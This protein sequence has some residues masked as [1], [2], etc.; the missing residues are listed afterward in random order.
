VRTRKRKNDPQNPKRSIPINDL[1]I[2]GPMK[3]E[4]DPNANRSLSVIVLIFMLLNGSWGSGQSTDATAVDAAGQKI[5][6]VIATAH[7]D[8]QWRWTIQKTI[9]EYIPNTLRGNFALLKKYPDYRFSFEGAFRYMLA[10]EYYPEDYDILRQYILDGRWNVCG[11]AVD[12]GDANI[13]SPESINRHIL[14]G[15]NYFR[16]EFGV[17]SRDIFLPDCF[18]FG[19][20]LPAVAAHCG[21]K[22]F[23]TQKLT[24]G[25]AYGVPFDIGVWEGVNGSSLVAELNPGAYISQIR[26]D[27]SQDSEWLKTINATGEKTSLYAGYKYF[28]V[29]DTGGAPDDS[30]IYWL[31]KSIKG[32]GP[33]KVISEAADQLCRDLSPEQIAKLP[34]YKGELL[35]STH[36][37]GCYTAQSAMKRW[38][39]HNELLADAAERAAVIAD[40]LGGAVYPREKLTTAWIRFLWHQFHDDLTGTSIPEA[41]G[42]SWNDEILS[43]NQFA[44]VL[45]DGVG[46]V[47]RGLDTQCEGVPIV[48]YNPLSIARRAVAQ[49]NVVFNNTIQSVQVFDEQNQEVPSQVL[50]KNG[51]ECQVL[52]LASVPPLGFKVYA[53]RASSQPC[54]MS[55]ELRAARDK[56]EN[57][58]YVV[59]VDANG[60]VSSIYDKS[61]RREL[62]TAPIQLQLLDDESIDWPAWEI[63]HREIVKPPRAFVSNPLKVEVAENGPVRV[64]I[65]IIRET[66]GST[67]TQFVRL[68]GGDDGNRVDFD[69]QIMWNTGGTLL[70]ACFPLTV[71]NPKATYDLGLG[72]IERP[73]NSEKLYE[74][75]AQQWADLTAV[76]GSYGIALLNDCKYGWDKP[77]DQTLRLTLIH[78]P[79]PGQNYVDQAG[80]DLGNHRMLF[81]VQGHKGPWNEGRVVWNAAGLN[82]PLLC[83]QTKPQKGQ[84][85]KVISF[86]NVNYADRVAIR[87]LKKSEEGDMM[88]VRLAELAGKPVENVQLS[89]HGAVESFRELNGAEEPLEKEAQDAALENGKLKFK[90]GPFQLRTFAV[91]L[92]KS[93]LLLTPPV[94]QPVD[95]GFDLDVACY[96]GNISDGNFDGRGHALAAELLPDV[97]TA[98]GITFKI[99]PRGIGQKNG[100]SCQGQKIKLPKGDFDC[101]YLL[102]AATEDTRDVFKV[103]GRK[104]D[105]AVQGYSGFI[106]QWDSRLQD[107][108]YPGQASIEGQ[109]VAASQITPSFIKKDNVAWVGTYR[110]D[111]INGVV[112]PYIFTYLYKYELELDS[113]ADQLTLP[114]NEKIRVFAVTM[115]KNPN[116]ATHVAQNLY[117]DSSMQS[118]VTVEPQGSVRYFRDSLQVALKSTYLDDQ[119][120]YSLDGSEPDQ[121]MLLY[122]EPFVIKE[123]TVVKAR[124]FNPVHGP[125]FI[126]VMPLNKVTNE[127]KPEN[128]ANTKSGLF[129]K[130][131]EG[132]WSQL[133]DF[134][135]LRIVKS[136]SIPAFRIPD[137]IRR[138]NF[139][140]L[141][142]GF[143]QIEKE[144]VYV[145][146][147]SSDDGSRLWIGTTRVVDNDGLHGPVE[148]AGAIYLEPGLHSIAVSFF[149]AGGG[150]DLT[151]NFEGPGISRQ[152]IPPEILFYTE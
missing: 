58:R 113:K 72:V 12:A 40:W 23:S 13:P 91:Q 126:S 100:S 109:S 95:L 86:A 70:K 51:K 16:K 94:C 115:A 47:C 148:A 54:Q 56:L 64:S 43:Q 62:L 130:Y 32:A 125:S 26:T 117:D 103:D 9:S 112:E 107:G 34:R 83:F 14:Y 78:T 84:L 144:G 87:A 131:Y 3:Q 139:A 114:V 57:N 98:E 122:K 55:T 108:I 119:I 106:G 80:M 97:I 123:A 111:T 101:L 88:I 75:P 93:P 31:E 81:S 135:S 68:A 74:V 50:N 133:P 35:M 79:K 147:T 105:V 2:G 39:R 149:Q 44:A 24:W 99:G 150:A 15:Q 33:I 104:Y 146:S 52:F 38:N 60:D 145:F 25:S 134:S 89:F 46:T 18:G 7:L 1:F 19:Y 36:G 96:A 140:L 118:K 151:V 42:F 110:H 59:I 37:T 143:I 6:H 27:L 10:K 120:R 4:N 45:Q 129:F 69:N 65:K 22:G 85:G 8:T 66:E 41:Y 63:L 29:G 121:T 127:H 20:A 142:D 116:A 5:L 48:V 28:G 102:A 136:G 137:N 76:D 141:F 128:P 152:I 67:F 138:D 73:N 53:V 71:S 61:A 21:L 90:I 17:T 11:S 92:A 77:D 30:S 124:A 82:Q 49:A 132:Q